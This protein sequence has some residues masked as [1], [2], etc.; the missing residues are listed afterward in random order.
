MFCLSTQRR[1]V[2]TNKQVS[3][4]T[5]TELTKDAV[6]TALASPRQLSFDLV[7]AYLARRSLDY[8]VGYTLSPL[9]WR[10][11]STAARSAGRRW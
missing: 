6:A 7:N 2:L 10:R 1:G 11:L 3:R 8:L 4:I 5:F 9:L